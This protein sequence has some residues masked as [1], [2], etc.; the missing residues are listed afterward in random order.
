MLKQEYLYRFDSRGQRFYV[1]AY[2]LRDA[3]EMIRWFDP[4][5]HLQR[6]EF[7]RHPHHVSI[8]SLCRIGFRVPY[9]VEKYLH[10]GDAPDHVCDAGTVSPMPK[11]E[12]FRGY[13]SL[14][15]ALYV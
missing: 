3:V 13:H 9:H 15:P 6:P 1:C 2:S 7:F 10:K 8:R 4:F 12:M 11:G 5:R 14:L